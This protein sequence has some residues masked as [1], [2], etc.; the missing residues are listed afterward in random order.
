M[1]AFIHL[2]AKFW[3]WALLHLLF[4]WLAV[5]PYLSLRSYIRRGGRVRIHTHLCPPEGEVRT[6][7]Q[8]SEA[9]VLFLSGV[10][11]V[12]S[13]TMSM[14]ERGILQRLAQ[15]CPTAV[16]LD[17][18]FAYSINNLPLTENRRLSQYWRWVMRQKLKKR[19]LHSLIGYLI[20]L[21]NIVQI[22]TSADTRY[23]QVY[24]AGF[25]RALLHHLRQ[26]GYDPTHPKP[27]FI[28]SYSGA[29]QIAAGAVKHL[30]QYGLPVYALMLACFFTEGPGV[31]Q[32]RHLWE[33]VG[34][35][36]VAYRFCYTFT[37]SRWRRWSSG[38]KHFVQ[39]GKMT[40][41]DMGAMRHTGRGGYL[42]RNSHL[43]CGTSYIDFTAIQ[44][45]NIINRV[46]AQYDHQPS[47]QKPSLAS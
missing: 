47:M 28:V 7:R 13:Q 33:F 36:D 16:V 4:L 20:N 6:Q 21:R 24:N 34:S 18:V 1:D 38:W 15:L 30:E 45:A 19:L 40:R 10:G 41:I 35:A 27:L 23:A 14:R 37:P 31:I 9:Y 42:D 8:P 39:E 17:D 46:C 12:S 22:A 26:Y 2:N 25:A 32:A 44:F 11:R 29:G 3:G 43:P 5:F